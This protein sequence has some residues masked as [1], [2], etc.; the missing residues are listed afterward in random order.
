VYINNVSAPN[1][2]T[3]PKS[4]TTGLKRIPGCEA[5]QDMPQGREVVFNGKKYHN[6]AISPFGAIILG[7]DG[8]Y[9]QELSRDKLM[10]DTTEPV[11]APFVEY[12][13]VQA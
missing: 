2:I 10:P 5:T 9:D 12:L 1:K 6:Y 8:T 7:S 11:I 4:K 3:I 13:Q